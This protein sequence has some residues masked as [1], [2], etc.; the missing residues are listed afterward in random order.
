MIAQLLVA[1]EE[2]VRPDATE[3]NISHNDHDA[4]EQFACDRSNLPWVIFRAAHRANH[5]AALP[6][7]ARCVLA[8]LARTVDAKR[9]YAAIFAR[10]ELLTGRAMQSMRTF[11]R[12][13]DDLEAA[14]LI[15]RTPQNR[16]GAA[17]LFG[18]AYLHLTE[19]AAA[20]LGIVEAPAVSHDV[21][22]VPEPVDGLLAPA[23]TSSG[24]PS[25][26]VADGAIYKDLD[27]KNQKRQP[28]TLPHDLQRLRSLGFHEFLIFKLMREARLQHKRLSEVVEVTWE[29]LSQA[30]RPIS[31]LRALLRSPVDFGHQARVAAARRAERLQAARERAAIDDTVANCAG[32]SFIDPEATRRFEVSADASTVVIHDHR[33]ARPRVGTGRWAPDFV[34]ALHNGQ[35]VPATPRLEGDFKRN[36]EARMGAQTLRAATQ[37][38]A[39]TVRTRTVDIDLRLGQMKSLLRAACAGISAVGRQDAPKGTGKIPPELHTA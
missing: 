8:A 15:T 20:V 1:S 34:A 24:S 37:T 19:A 36:H 10:R 2:L 28:G 30:N 17:G 27:P 5:I 7:R 6:A 13:L 35:I 38:P 12:S 18:R 22:P 21:A 26:S 39:T 32:Q 33:E 25:A 9:P 4:F 29:H 11:Y 14:G 3:P 31:Y 16:H 23:P